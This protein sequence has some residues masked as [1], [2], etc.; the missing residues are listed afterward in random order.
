MQSKA[1]RAFFMRAWS[2]A[3]VITEEEEEVGVNIL[4]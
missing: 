4:V 1:V 2:W 3:C